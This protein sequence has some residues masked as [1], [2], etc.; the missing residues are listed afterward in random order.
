MNHTITTTLWDSLFNFVNA[1]SKKKNIT[2]KSIIEKGLKYYKK[3]EMEMQVKQ[4]LQARKAEYKQLNS[5]FTNI[6]FT[7]IN[8]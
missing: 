4:W 3:H 8:D 6:Q 7:S 5:E 1:E 2:K